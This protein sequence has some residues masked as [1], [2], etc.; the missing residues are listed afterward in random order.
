MKYTELLKINL[1]VDVAVYGAGTIGRIIYNELKE[2][3]NI[4]IVAWSDQRYD[5]IKDTDIKIINPKNIKNYSCQMIV[6]TICDEKIIKTII[7]DL[8]NMGYTNEIIYLTQSEL[9]KIMKKEINYALLNDDFARNCFVNRL[10]NYNDDYD[11]LKSELY[12]FFLYCA[13]IRYWNNSVEPTCWYMGNHSNIAYLR[14]AKCACTSIISTLV[15]E[16]EEDIHP[17]AAKKYEI[18]GNISNMK[19]VYKFTFVRNPFERLVSNYVNKVKN[20]EKNNYYKQK[21]YCMGILNDIFDFE[22]FVRRVTSIPDRWADRH[23]KQQYSY[24]YDDNGEL[25]VDYIGKVENLSNDYLKI[26]QKYGL[27]KLEWKNKS[28]KENWKTFY[29]EETA[30]L[31]YEYYKNDIITFGYEKI[32]EEL[33]MYINTTNV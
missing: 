21:D 3:S 32:Y 5:R 25:L 12:K 18:T 13:K 24:L 2:N 20:L 1:S 14:L 15:Q 19:S 31:V 4:N 10:L 30:K 29:T 8:I 27:K 7:N 33:L 16:D 23:F 17:L 6:I 28:D 26:Q 9:L 11:K 22:E